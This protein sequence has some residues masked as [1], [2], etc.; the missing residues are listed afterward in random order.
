MDEQHLDDMFDRFRSGPPLTVPAGAG[1]ARQSFRQRRRGRL[2]AGCVVAALG[3]GVPSVAFAAG[4]FDRTPRPPVVTTAP[5]TPARP[6]PPSTTPPP[7]TPGAKPTTEK[8]VEPTTVPRAA[9][10]R[11]SDLPAGF[12]YRGGGDFLGGDWTLAFIA[13]QCRDRRLPDPEPGDGPKR[14]A[15]FAHDS[16]GSVL[17]RVSRMPT[18]AAARDWIDGLPD[19]ISGDCGG[20]RFTVVDTDFAGA[21]AVLIRSESDAGG[22]DFLLFVRQGPLVTQISTWSGADLG[23]LRD[24]AQA[25]AQRLCAG[26][27]SC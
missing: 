5:T 7:T 17:Q 24:I 6:T 8:P 2:A 27:T 4:A 10:L 9:M 3:V 16:E 23:A 14:N 19:R 25:A 22:S 13:S 20:I 12:E 15:A 21:D 26:T 18:P 1:A 11:A